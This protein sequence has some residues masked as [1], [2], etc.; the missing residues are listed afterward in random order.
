R[1]NSNTTSD[2]LSDL[3]LF[4]A[5]FRDKLCIDSTIA[6]AEEAYAEKIED[7]TFEENF[8][9][10]FR[11][12]FINLSK[13][14]SNLSREENLDQILF[15]NA[16]YVRL[17]PGRF[18]SKVVVIKL[19]FTNH[20]RSQTQFLKQFNDIESAFE[21]ALTLD[22]LEQTEQFLGVKYVKFPDVV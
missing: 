6:W 11:S 1:S 19:I 16:N 17:L 14:L 20:E 18:R 5:K 7:Y 3:K 8:C 9:Q 2:I 4:E 22:V 13:P 12:S 10:G 15:E 21:F